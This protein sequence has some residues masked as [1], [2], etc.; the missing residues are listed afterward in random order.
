VQRH[1]SMVDP[2]WQK[3]NE[4]RHFCH[5]WQNIDQRTLPAMTIFLLLVLLALAVAGF[6]GWGA[7]D[8]RDV[9]F[10]LWPLTGRSPSP[11]GSSNH[12]RP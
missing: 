7:A 11:S 12:S 10:S 5:W 8:T 3:I 9:R 1:G 4:P 2:G 6:T